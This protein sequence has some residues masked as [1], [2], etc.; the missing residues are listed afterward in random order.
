MK[1][2]LVIIAL[3]LVGCK[4]SGRLVV[5][6]TDVS[7]SESSSTAKSQS[8]DSFENGPSITGLPF[9]VEVAAGLWN[10]Q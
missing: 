6:G 5:G 7:L 2:I 8:D 1:Y 3:F 4:S 9:A 10:A